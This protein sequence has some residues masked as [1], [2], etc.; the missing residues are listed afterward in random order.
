LSN[1]Y[2]FATR[3]SWV[4]DYNVNI[5]SM[6][7]SSYDSNSEIDFLQYVNSIF[8]DNTILLGFLPS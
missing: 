7:V 5:H 8:S 1:N 3:I 6:R 2:K 4:V